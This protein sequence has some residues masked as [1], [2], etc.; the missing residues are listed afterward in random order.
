M[1]LYGT[2]RLRPSSANS[3]SEKNSSPGMRQRGERELRP[4]QV[5]DECR[6]RPVG[7]TVAGRPYSQHETRRPRTR[8]RPRSR[9]ARWPSRGGPSRGRAPT[10]T[11]SAWSIPQPTISAASCE[12]SSTSAK[13]PL[14]DGPSSRAR[15]M[16]V[17]KMRIASPNRVTI[18]TS[19]SRSSGDGPSPPAA[20]AAVGAATASAADSF[21]GRLRSLRAGGGVGRDRRRGPDR[22]APPRTRPRSRPSP[23]SSGPRRDSRGPARP[24]RPRRRCAGRRRRA[25]ARGRISSARP[26]AR[27]IASA[28]PA[29]V[30][31]TPVPAWNSS[32]ATS[33]LRR[34]E[35]GDDRGRQVVDVD[36]VAGLLRRPRG[37]SIGSPASAARSQAA[38]TL[39]LWSEYGP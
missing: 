22:R 13:R 26:T 4:G 9:R 18:V 2:T 28:S 15:A 38:T 20:R 5:R 31:S 30:V 10:T 36:E 27:P 32:P 37:S 24:C 19:A 7:R 6:Q 34:V 35:G 12:Y 25:P 23:S 33:V 39:R 17:A 14:A 3:P 1:R 16:S 11:A 8:R 29:I 21:I